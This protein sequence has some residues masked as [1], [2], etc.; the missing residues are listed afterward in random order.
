M[1]PAI[2]DALSML[3]QVHPAIFW[4]TLAFAFLAFVSWYSSQT[5]TMANKAAFVV[6]A[7]KKH[8][9]TVIM[10]HGLGDR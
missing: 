4:S 6:P 9:A 1:L 8:T 10:A 2:T 3:T 7:L 5:S